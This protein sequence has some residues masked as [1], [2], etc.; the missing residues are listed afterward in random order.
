MSH[1]GRQRWR[2]GKWDLKFQSG[3][4]REA[5]RS[6]HER[7]GDTVAVDAAVD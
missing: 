5:I 2:E 7:F 1:V 3:E 4:R 6:L